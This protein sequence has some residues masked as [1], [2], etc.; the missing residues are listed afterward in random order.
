MY[1]VVQPGVPLD[2]IR[3]LLYAHM[4]KMHI[5]IILEG[6]YWTTNQDEALNHAKIYLIFWDICSFSIL[7]GKAPG[8][9]QC[10]M[11][12]LVVHTSYIHMDLL[13]ILSR[14]HHLLLGQL[15]NSM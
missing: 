6:K 9:P 3:I 11:N 2:E 5:A 12:Y 13:K 8:I 1:N 14:N 4:Y 10:L 7:Q 15:F